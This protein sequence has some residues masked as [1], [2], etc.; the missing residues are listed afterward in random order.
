V[1][2]ELIELCAG[3]PLALGLI[4]AR[5]TADPQLPLADIAA[6]LRALGLDALESEELTA[7]LPAVLSWSL[8]YLTAQQRHVFA[9]LGPS[10][11]PDI[12]LPA[13]ATLTGLPEREAHAV[14]QALTDASLINRTPGG[15]YAMH[16]LV[17]AYATTLADTLPTDVRETALRRVLDFYTHTAHTAGR[18]LNPHRD[19]PPFDPATAE[20][21]THPLADAAAAL[22]WFDTE[23]ACLLAA[24]HTAATNAW[25]AT[26]WWLAWILHTVHRRRGHLHDRATTWQAAADAASHLPDPTTRIIALRHLGSAHA[27]LGRHEDGLAHLHQALTIAEHHH[28]P[29]ERAHTHYALTLAWEQQGND[30]KALVHSRRALELYRGLNHPVREAEALNA[31]GWYAARLGDYDTARRHCHAA[32]TLHRH[33]HH[34]EGE[35]DT[36][37]SLGYIEH[38][39]GH[40]AQAINHYHHAVTLRRNLGNTYEAANT[41]DGLGHPHAVLG[42]IEQARTVWH[43]ALQLYR[44]QGRHDD[45]MRVRRHLDNLG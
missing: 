19:P 38:H 21:H 9:L 32:L 39:S 13:A 17:R 23:H 29:G 37:D 27:R 41:L 15:R 25:H 20:V 3:F 35:A 1:V 14:L 18:L 8:R 7:S 10:P 2:T 31:V 5:A 16:D 28:N 40:H 45:A 6:E 43:E 24:Q 4:A 33:H 26:T 30:R 34:A 12:G 22:A 44:D 11:G 42:Q 36:L